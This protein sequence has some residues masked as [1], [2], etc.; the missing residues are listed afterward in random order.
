MTPKTAAPRK[1]ITVSGQIAGVVALGLSVAFLVIIG[2]E[3][4]RFR[5]LIYDSQL[6]HNV[7]TIQ[8]I[9][10]QL[11]VPLTERKL[12]VIERSYDSL[13]TQADM[14]VV[15]VL[16][17]DRDG[18]AV[19]AYSDPA[20]PLDLQAIVRSGGFE[21]LDRGGGTKTLG[22]LFIVTA[23]VLSLD[24]DVRGG[25]LA[26]AWDLSPLRQMAAAEAKRELAIA[27]VIFAAFITLALVFVRFR[28]GKPLAEITHATN[29]IANGDKRFEVPW[30]DRRDEIGDMARSLV[31]FR[32]NVALI[33]RL[34]A[35]QQQQT[36]RLSEAL[37]KERQYNALHR[38]FVSMVS[39][40][41]RTPVAIIDGAA[42]RIDRRAGKDTPEDLRQ[43]TTKIRSAVRRMIELI[44][45][46]LSLSR[47]E[48][49]NI[50]LELEDCD[51]AALLREVC[52]RQQEIAADHKIGLIIADMPPSVRLDP[53]RMDQVF[54]NL[55]S[56][57]VKYSPQAP[58]IDVKA[59]MVGG[60][61]VVS[62]RDRG[63]GIPKAE[64]PKL[65]EKF[66][67]ASTSTGIPGT[68]IGLHLVRHLVEL[69]S[70]SATVDSVEGEGTTV[71]I[72]LP[73]TPADRDGTR[74]FAAQAH[75]ESVIA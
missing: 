56:N 44:D 38:E 70:G 23:P 30:T 60:R 27:L 59:G 2:V 25:T 36:M 1:V 16:T 47:I 32:E 57:A 55:L 24:G 39:H 13:I 71:S 50:D 33:D 51:L 75:P 54:T 15:G 43:R 48:A 10:S 31:T 67:R 14:T 69:H 46:T 63:L 72:T 18:R 11:Y 35:E 3:I 12:A 64:L 6:R 5:S 49:G 8:L 45:S 20:I 41:F 9:A 42:Q 26:I 34:T 58:R 37:E 53:K 7:H 65:F 73:V 22:D 21:P 52:Q 4:Q 62:V 40:E 17:L 66:F 19:T 61:I 28:L 74:T 68:G 29:R